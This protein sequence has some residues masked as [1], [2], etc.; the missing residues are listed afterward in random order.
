MKKLLLC[1]F[2]IFSVSVFG[3]KDNLVKS[4]YEN[5]NIKEVLSFNEK[6]K[7]D[8]ICLTYSA[9]GVQTGLAS[10]K[11]GIKHG[12]WKIW[13]EDGTLVYEMFYENGVKTGIWKVY[14]ERGELIKKRDFN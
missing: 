1:L 4:Y 2:L 3:Q 12:E 13:R 11:D 10:Y 7:L 5:G 9:D 6:E 8:G 14:N